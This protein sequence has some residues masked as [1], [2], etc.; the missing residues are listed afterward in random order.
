MKEPKAQR[1]HGRSVF[2]GG[3]GS[4]PRA[5]ASRTSAASSWSSS[6]MDCAAMRQRTRWTYMR[7]THYHLDETKT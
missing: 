1:A 6:S 3:H 5:S 7:F 2:S 4:I